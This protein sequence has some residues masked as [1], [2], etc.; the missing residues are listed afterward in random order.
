MSK[1]WIPGGGGGADLDVVTA[2]TGDVLSGKVIVDKDGNPLTGTMPDNTSLTSNGTVP[3]I[4]S[5]FPDVPTREGS[6]L[7]INTATDGVVRISMCPPSGYYPGAANDGSYVNRPASD[8][9]NAPTSAI[10]PD[11]TA[12]SQHGLKI[13]GTMPTM[14]GGTKTPTTSQQTISCRGKKMTS[15]IVIPAFSLPSA[16]V[17]LVGKTVTI[18]GKS[19]TGTAQQYLQNATNFEIVN[20]SNTTITG[21]YISNGSYIELD[22]YTVIRFNTARNLTNYKYL[23]CEGSKY[24]AVGVSKNPNNTGV[25]WA[26]PAATSILDIGSLSDMYFIYIKNTSDTKYWA[27]RITFSNS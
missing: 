22:P 21:Y 16:S 13:R 17:I 8:F 1:I 19:V 11:Y 20:E 5:S 9:G 3:G 15:D 27:R 12:T 18:Y 6:N 4:S 7:Q 26:S 10:D 2:G 25:T 23:K 24:V 14:A